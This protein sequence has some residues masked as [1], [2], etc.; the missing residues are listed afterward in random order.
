M[1]FS[2][3]DFA[4]QATGGFARNNLFEVTISPSSQHVG[5]W[6]SGANAVN[7]SDMLKMRVK[8]A[9]LPGMQVGTLDNKR[10][11][12]AFKVVNE[13]IFEPTTWTVLCSEDMRER[14]FFMGWMSWIH[15]SS[16]ET[17]GNPAKQFRPRY[18]D[19]YVGIANIIT[20]N[21]QGESYY[22]AQLIDCFPTSMGPVEQTWGDGAVS[23][24]TVTL[25]FR[26][27]IPLS[28][29][30]G[31]GSSE[32]PADPVPVAVKAILSKEERKV[33]KTEPSK[34]WPMHLMPDGTSIPD[35]KWR[36]MRQ[37]ENSARD[38]SSWPMHLTSGGKAVPHKIY[39]RR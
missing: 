9:Q 8:A 29:T 17:A 22:E 1:A 27:F 35:D 10:F 16:S 31:S 3:G 14:N 26:Y 5:G 18:Y 2:V 36:A 21:I 19:E 32:K 13:V 33:E 34:A 28:S 15:G 20:Y 37:A 4:K 23:E 30:A 39:N 6:I 24:F 7:A 25:N 11:G 12:P 38:S